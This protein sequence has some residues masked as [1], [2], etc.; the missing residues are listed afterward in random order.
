MVAGSLAE[1]T[2]GMG[3][4][5]LDREITSD[6]KATRLLFLLADIQHENRLQCSARSFVDLL[7][8]VFTVDD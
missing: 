7:K 8:T 4:S 6:H 1:G 2:A 3:I 5:L